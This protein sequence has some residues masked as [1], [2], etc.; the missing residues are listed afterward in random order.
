MKV[1]QVCA[2][3]AT[4][5]GNFIASLERLEERLQDMGIETIYAFVE[6]AAKYN[7]CK[8]IQKRAKV[9][10]LPEVKAR[11]LPKTYK[12][13]KKIY[14]E[15][16]ISVIHTHFELYDIPATVTAPKDVKIFWH[17]HDPITLQK[18]LRKYLWKFQY[19]T[20][21]K[22]AELLSVADYYRESV[23]KMGFPKRQTNIVLNCIDLDR[24]QDCSQ[25]SEKEYDFLTFGWDFYRKGDDLILK[26]CE[27][28]AKEG[29]I[30]KLLLNG[31]DKTWLELDNFLQG[32]APSYLVKGN[33]VEDVNELFCISK[34]FI[35]ASRKE[36]FSY[37]V[38]EAAY[39]GLPIISSDIAGLEWAHDLPSIDFFETENVDSL[40]DKMKKYLD[41][42]KIE[43]KTMK[44]TQLVVSER[45]SLDVWVNKIL[46]HYDIK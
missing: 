38:C 29:Y 35:Q 19:G 26:A 20:V 17:L 25:L 5:P 36:T 45:Y 8:S 14:K 7:W 1:L 10:F 18:G 42:K 31:N 39:A 12:I 46:Y 4:Y 6:K 3:G 23:I 32:S 43:S 2:Y 41:G 37:A 24:I 13:F 27:R 9:Y 11:I 28:L 16:D 40:F 33:P 22:K 44:Q 15:H 34:V 30:F 21:G